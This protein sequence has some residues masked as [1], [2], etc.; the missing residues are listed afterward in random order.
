M[1]KQKIVIG[2]GGFAGIKAAIELADDSRFDITL[3][4]NRRE[5]QIYGSLY[6]TVTGGSRFVSSVPLTEIFKDRQINIV[7]DSIKNIDR[8]SQKLITAT[9]KEFSYNALILG[10]GM[11][12]NYFGIKG[13]A[14][15]SYG[16]KSLAEAAR[17]KEHLH[18]QLTNKSVNK[19]HYIVVGGG[20]T[21]VELAGAL[22]RY[23]K[24]ISKFHDLP[25][26]NIHV[27]LIEAAP[28]LLPRLPKDIGRSVLKNLRKNGVR[29]YLNTI[30]QAQTADELMIHNTPI[31]SHTVVWTAGMSNN[32]FFAEN[33]F[34]LTPR[35]IVRVDQYLQ[36]EPGIY[37]LGDN[38]DTP[39]SGMAQTALYDGNYVAK[40]LIRRLNGQETLP[41][42]AKKP[43]YVMPAGDKWA[44]VLWGKVRLYG[45]IGWWLRRMADLS[46]YREY[47][48]WPLAFSR[49]LADGDR[50]ESCP[51]CVDNHA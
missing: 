32:P 40:N 51:L 28:R 18:T 3:I 8:K 4:S 9:N 42:K 44:A 27:D 30:V 16:I 46:A 41:Y 34:Q 39:Y 15:Y 36:A 21:G 49:F 13:L 37:V 43:I 17:L 26:S 35:G 50:Q 5:L 33:G 6:H 24:E 10:L 20:P 11:Q 31:R 29:V 45:R 12:T 14:E 1:S 22:P 23:I 2:G 19:M 7:I 38:A 48:S 25:I 47:T